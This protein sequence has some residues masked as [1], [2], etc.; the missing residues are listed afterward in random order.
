[1]YYKTEYHDKGEL[2]SDN[3]NVP[4]TEV[5]NSR[6]FFEKLLNGFWKSEIK[7]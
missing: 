5:K 4:W 6:G 3:E 2:L 7:N 1:M